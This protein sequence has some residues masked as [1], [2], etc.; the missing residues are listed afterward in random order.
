M[1]ILVI[2]N[3]I[4]LNCWGSQD[5]CKWVTQTSS[6][7]TVYVRRG[8]Q[9]DLPPSPVRYDRIVVSGSKSSAF[10]EKPWVD[11]L[12][13]FMR[14]AMQARIPL[15][16]ICFGHQILA[17]AVAGDLTC[18]NKSK[19]PEFGW[20]EIQ[21]QGESSLTA[22]LPK[23]FYSF[24]AHFEEVKAAPLGTRVLAQSKNC[25]IQAFEVEGIPAY[26][27]QFHPEKPLE[28]GARILQHRQKVGRPKN[29]F[30]DRRDQTLYNPKVGETLFKNF[31]K[32]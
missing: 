23:T 26:G 13:D 24:S 20:T 19:V 3:N 29:L 12:I 11:A 31:L 25:K 8:P 6:Q 28:E 4:D 14:K 27:V 9:G 18:L 21:L 15:L 5:I 1:K 32:E 17:R 7:N 10:E 16:G 30:L 22:G 2:D